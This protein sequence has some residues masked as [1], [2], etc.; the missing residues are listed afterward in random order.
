[1]QI[2]VGG[3]GRIGTYLTEAL[4]RDGHSVLVVDRDN[5]RLQVL[6]RSFDVAVKQGSISDANLLEK[7]FEDVFDFFIAVTDYDEANVLSCMAAKKLENIKTVARLKSNALLRPSLDGGRIFHIDHFVVPELLVAEQIARTI[8]TGSQIAKKFFFGAAELRLIT[9]PPQWQ[10]AGIPLHRLKIASISMVIGAIYRTAPLPQVIFPHGNDTLAIGDQI[11]V[12]AESSSFDRVLE[13]FNLQDPQPNRVFISGGNQI[14]YQ[15]AQLLSG[16]VSKIE[17]ADVSI[18]R[19]RYLARHLKGASILHQTTSDWEFL[20]QQAISQSDWFVGCGV[21][22]ERNTLISLLAKELGCLGVIACISD[23]AERKLAERLGLS[24]VVSERIASTDQIL[25]WIHKESVESILSLFSGQAEVVE[26]RIS[27]DSSAI[28]IPIAQLGPRLPKD[29][30]IAVIYSRGRLL[31]AGGNHILS[32][33][34]QVI[35]V[36]SPRHRNLLESIF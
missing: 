14:G 3:A 32:P 31:I 25:T 17:I 2:L 15:V 12:V 16:H 11:V 4:C 35:I 24:Y 36:T 1:M 34:D 10:Y 27:E 23:E 26:I 33:G 8:K 13:F 28:G 20:R 21:N 7:L 19:C 5:E 6:S 30:L 22:E 29:L 9:I 18:E